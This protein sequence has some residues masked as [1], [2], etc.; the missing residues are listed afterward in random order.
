MTITKQRKEA[1]IKCGNN[2]VIK[3]SSKERKAPGK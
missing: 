1:F 3:I 2:K